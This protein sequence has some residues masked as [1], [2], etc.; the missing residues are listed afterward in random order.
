MPASGLLDPLQTALSGRYAVTGEIGRGATAI[1]VRARD[2]RHDRDVAIK[3]LLPELAVAIGPERFQREITIVARLRHPHIL[4]LLDAGEN[5]GL[6]WYAMPYVEGESLRARLHRLRRLPVAEAVRFACEVAAALDRAHRDEVV[7][8]DIK[9]ENI[10][11]D[12]EVAV[13]TDFGIARARGAPAAG[14]AVT[15]QDMLM[16]TPPYMSPEQVTGATDL[17]A[18]SDVYSLGCVLYEMLTGAAPFR[19]PATEVLAHHALTPAPDPR[20]A[21]AEVPESVAA[22]VR[23]AM[24]KDPAQRFAGARAFAEALSGGGGANATPSMLGRLRSAFATSASGTPSPAT[25]P[26][27][28]AAPLGTTPP[29][30]APIESLAV[31]PFA[32]QGGEEDTACLAE[33]IADGIMS[34]LGGIE[35]LR[36]VP[37]SVVFR[38]AGQTDDPIGIARELGVR[39]V[40]TG[41]LHQRGER[42]HVSVELLD[43]SRES[44]LWAERY[45]RSM[46][47]ILALQE[48]M[49]AEVARSLRLRPSGEAQRR[50]ARRPTDDPVAYRAYLRGRHH[51]Q[52]RTVEGLRQ[53]IAHF[54]EAIAHDPSFALA[55]DGLA[56]AFHLLGCHN[57]QPP[58][59]A[60]PRATMASQRALELDP[61]LA[62]A[63]ASL[64][65]ARLVFDR[66]WAG[67]AA[68]LRQALALDPRHPTAHQWLAWLLMAAERFDEAL[69]S[70]QRA[71]DLDPL[72]LT[73]NDHLGYALLLAGHPHPALQQLQRTRELDPTFPWTYG[74]LGDAYTALGRHD[75]AVDAYGTVVERTGGGVGLGWLALA[76]A[77]AGNPAGAQAALARLE[78]QALERY[79]SPFERAMAL[80]ATGRADETFTALDRAA[81]ERVSDL[82]RLRLV[83]WPDAIRQ[84]PRFD[85]LA[86]RLGLPATLPPA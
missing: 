69:A 25:P 65:Y 58:M 13:V 36:I 59:E 47:D 5:A 17:D 19:G 62:S 85:A 18:R 80:A 51:V 39:A 66:D 4:P 74:R 41:R 52:A 56:D 16:G 72:N 28:P 37:R 1:V 63:H 7:H 76:E 24:E 79:T 31:L 67:A 54:E 60:F 84:D 42:L 83:A 6:L 21:R 2:L 53:A 61:A 34:K 10:L 71:H 35:G 50:L 55:H 11:L 38:Y 3:V 81:D 14:D 40:V 48:E 49:V 26:G 27:S 22:A 12:R 44:P 32:A 30:R 73:I 45:E 23:R 8:R 78:A 77:A 75:D 46:H 57:T 20:M 64:G 29:G 33:G 43:A 86:R 15:P 82:V 68:S 9:P 70:L